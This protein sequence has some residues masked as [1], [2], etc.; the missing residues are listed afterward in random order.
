MNSET[1]LPDPDSEIE[2]PEGDESFPEEDL[3]LLYTAEDYQEYCFHHEPLVREWAID[4]LVNIYPEEEATLKHIFLLL[5]FMADFEKKYIDDDELGAIPLTLNDDP[6]EY[7]IVSDGKKNGRDS[8]EIAAAIMET[9][10]DFRTA[11]DK[12]A[13]ENPAEDW[14]E[15][16]MAGYQ[17]HKQSLKYK[18]IGYLKDNF[19]RL[20]PVKVN[21]YS[22]AYFYS[23][24]GYLDPVIISY[25]YYFYGMRRTGGR[26]IVS[27]IFN[28]INEFEE[29]LDLNSLGYTILSLKDLQTQEAYQFLKNLN[30][31]LK[32]PDGNNIFS[33]FNALLSY[34]KPEDVLLLLE[35]VCQNLTETNIEMIFLELSDLF[36][37]QEYLDYFSIFEDIELEVAFAEIEN[38]WPGNSALSRAIAKVRHCLSRFS[39]KKTTGIDEIFMELAG[40]L[41][42]ELA[43]KYP[44]LELPQLP[45]GVEELQPELILEQAQELQE[46]SE[47]DFWLSLILSQ[48]LQRPE[49]FRSKKSGYILNFLVTMLIVL[50]EDNDFGKKLGKLLPEDP[51]PD[52]K[53]Q[54]YREASR[55]LHQKLSDEVYLNPKTTA[56]TDR[57]EAPLEL[58][59][60]QLE[61]LWELFSLPRENIPEEVLELMYCFGEH[62]SQELHQVVRNSLNFV[63]DRKGEGQLEANTD[64]TGEEDCQDEVS[65]EKDQISQEGKISRAEDEN[66]EN[67]GQG[68]EV[69]NNSLA[70][71]SP[72]EQLAFNLDE[73][74]SLT[75][76]ADAEETDRVDTAE[77]DTTTGAADG[78]ETEEFLRYFL[79]RRSLKVLGRIGYQPA[80]PDIIK[81]LQYYQGDYITPA[82][83][84]AL[85]EMD[86]FAPE[87]MQEAVDVGD[88]T[89]VLSFLDTLRKKPC[90]AGVK[91]VIAWYQRGQFTIPE[92][93]IL[94][95]KDMGSRLGQRFID[96]EFHNLEQGY[97]YKSRIVL[98]YLTGENLSNVACYHNKIAEYRENM[99]DAYLRHLLDD[100]SDDEFEKVLDS[101]EEE[102]RELS[103]KKGRFNSGPGG[104]SSIAA[105]DKPGSE[106]KRTEEGAIVRKREKVGRNDPCPCGSGKKYKKC[107]L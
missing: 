44:Q 51:D 31:D 67:R 65:S 63:R 89:T 76:A 24:D 98:A 95:L 33:Y 52:R 2:L 37:G 34:R 101:F 74:A 22:G 60:S 10:Q 104:G 47:E 30:P 93:I 40:L 58:Q 70:H 85:A 92:P 4:Q 28:F 77:S 94:F 56:E 36:W 62:F 103:A 53:H 66:R 46:L 102:R 64:S 81:L 32:I 9:A 84:Q 21:I 83:E 105:E 12:F 91:L 55:A 97:V 15:T 35:N 38:N 6:R 106:Y 14:L 26:K 57:G 11:S 41:R 50:L 61:L 3:E 16:W 59:D 90:L 7:V 45:G 49:I 72:G 29:E 75:A 80:G 13:R 73:S 86:F 25:V 18:L 5:K 39:K 71:C 8:D 88:N 87:L 19:R 100:M 107:C 43:A 1:S 27:D 42:D 23:A 17:R 78:T 54:E 96:K 68:D 69:Q 79:L 99:P 48:L 82:A 20:D